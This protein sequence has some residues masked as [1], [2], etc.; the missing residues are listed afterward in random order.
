M[1][2]GIDCGAR[3]VKAVVLDSGRVVARG[4][5][6]AGGDLTRVAEELYIETLKKA[7]ITRETVSRL[8]ATGSGRHQ[9]NFCD[10]DVSEITAGAKGA[11]FLLPSARTVI[12]VGA[13]ETR[14]LRLDSKG[15]VLDFVLNDKC[16][17]GVG[18]FVEAMAMALEVSVK[19]LGDLAL[20][21]D[22]SIQINSQCVVFAETEVI[23]LVHSRIPKTHVAKAIFDAIADRVVSLGRKVGFE[24]DVVLIGGLANSAGFIASIRRA[25]NL[26]VVVPED[27]DFVTA[28]GAALLALQG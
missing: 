25:M 24:P 17:A 13:E 21:G 10:G 23:S 15:R 3:T 26:P 28:L 2:A 27:P 20:Q 4:M 14:A 19:E 7:E 16:A 18:L 1:T 5:A 11:T 22:S 6:K 8:L 9:V 12:D